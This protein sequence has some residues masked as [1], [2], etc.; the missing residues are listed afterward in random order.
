MLAKKKPSGG[1]PEWALTYGDMMSLLLCFFILLAAFADYEKGGGASDQMV[2]A[3]QSIQSAL[4]IKLRD[5]PG[6]DKMSF[7]GLVEQIRKL[8]QARNAEYKGDTREQGLQGRTFRLRRIRDGME[9]VIGGPIL[10]E[11]FSTQVTREGRDS[12]ERIGAILRGHRNKIEVIGHAAEQAPPA[13]WGYTDA[14]QL[15]YERARHVAEE[16]VRRGVDPRAMRLVSVGANEPLREDAANLNLV[17]EGRRVEIIVRESLIDDYRAEE[18]A[19]T[20][21]SRPEGLAS[22]PAEAR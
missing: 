14:I 3:M 5:V 17:G 18:A 13:D 4:G 11:P 1:A 7:N 10:F 22:A 16:L 12:L 2:A 19:R 8:V 6:A 15:S 21:T 20:T 9:L